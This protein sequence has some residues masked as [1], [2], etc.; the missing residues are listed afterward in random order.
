MI[1]I[2]TRQKIYFAAAI[3]GMILLTVT[4]H[5]IRT[6]IEINRL[7]REAA[8]FSKQADASERLAA[9]A[10]KNAARQSARA[11]LLEQQ[12]QEIRVIATKQDEELKKL[13]SDTDA[14]RSRVDRARRLRS[15]ESST[16]ELC[17]K[18]ES[19]GHGCEE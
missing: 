11:E 4:V 5:S 14:A 6:W 15:I 12:L 10:E 3:T 13:A 17:E 7:E 1:S 9:E 16:G 19:L 8:A 2:T 18:L